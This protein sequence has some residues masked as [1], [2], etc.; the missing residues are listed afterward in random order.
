M[1]RSKRRMGYQREG[2]Q[3][4]LLA[5]KLRLWNQPVQGGFVSNIS[6]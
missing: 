4:V 1:F 5:S 2:N 6:P 3:H